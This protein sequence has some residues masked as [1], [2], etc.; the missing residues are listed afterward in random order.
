MADSDSGERNYDNMLRMLSD[1]NKDLEKLLEEMEKISGRMLSKTACL[2]FNS[3]NIPQ[4]SE[5]ISSVPS[6]NKAFLDHL[7]IF[8]AVAVPQNLTLTLDDLELFSVV[9]HCISAIGLLLSS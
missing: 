5:L 7:P 6:P 8:I 1:L 2:L 9:L 3:L 4:T